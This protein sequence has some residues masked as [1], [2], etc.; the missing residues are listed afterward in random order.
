[1]GRAVSVAWLA[2]GNSRQ[3]IIEVVVMRLTKWTDYSLRVLM[4][5]AATQRRAQAPTI[6]EIAERHAISRSHLMKIVMTLSA[7]GW[8]ESTR[9][10]GG[11]IRLLKPADQISIGAVVRETETDFHMVECFDEAS[12]TCHLDRVC[13]L[14][15]LL[16]EAT[17]R[18]LAVLD[19]VTLADLMASPGQVLEQPLKRLSVKA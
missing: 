14:K 6:G 3:S 7:L 9:G 10:R 12:N 13:K 8:I 1:M 4:H 15:T 18:Y 16:E 5:C 2:C 11:G 17:E 19:G